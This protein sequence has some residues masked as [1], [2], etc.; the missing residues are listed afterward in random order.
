MKSTRS[1]SSTVPEMPGTTCAFTNE[2]QQRI[3]TSH[4]KRRSIAAAASPTSD[5]SK[6][7]LNVVPFVETTSSSAT[8]MVPTTAVASMEKYMMADGAAVTLTAVVAIADTPSSSRTR[9]AA[10]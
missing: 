2:Q 6:K 4:G 10:V 1:E 5:P 9:R 3:G 7:R 8:V